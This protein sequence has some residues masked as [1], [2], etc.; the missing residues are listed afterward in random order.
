MTTIAIKKY[1]K[2]AWMEAGGHLND[3]E[4]FLFDHALR[5]IRVAVL[6]SVWRTVMNERGTVNGMDSATVLTYALAAEVFAQQLGART[7]IEWQIWEGKFATLILRPMG[8]ITALVSESAGRWIVSFLVVSIPLLLLA[9]A[10]GVN[11]LPASAAHGWA[12]VVSL[13][14]AVT[15]ALA[16]DFTFCAAAVAINTSVWITESFRSAVTALLA[17]SMIPL[18]LLPWGLGRI[19]EWLP[20]ASMASAPL[21]IYTGTGNPATLIAIQ[22]MWAIILWP[23]ANWFWNVNREKLASYGG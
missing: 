11:P 10:F 16:I 6:I 19:L 17:G 21:R 13:A 2:T 5:F 4:S 9:P 23:L 3:G 12:F 20:F 22:A 7:Y 8:F 18:A 15:V 1:A 14:L